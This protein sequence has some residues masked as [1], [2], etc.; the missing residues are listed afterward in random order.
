M[1]QSN[2][3]I[4]ILDQ[5]QHMHTI[6]LPEQEPLLRDGNPR[7]IVILLET[8]QGRK[9]MTKI[10]GI[11]WYGLSVDD[12]CKDLTRRCASSVTGNDYSCYSL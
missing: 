11:E 12:A 6:T 5:M 1:T 9:T 10:T 8:R 2:T 4:R 7:N 3:T